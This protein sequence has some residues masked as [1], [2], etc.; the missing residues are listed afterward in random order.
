MNPQP[1]TTLLVGYGNECRGDDGLGPTVARLVDAMGLPEVSVL[2]V[3]QLTPELAEPL[4]AAGRAVFVDARAAPR[5]SPITVE[6]LEAACA[7]TVLT[8]SCRPADLL[9]LCQLLYGHSPPAWLVTI[10]GSRFDPG[11]SLSRH[12]RR[13]ADQAAEMLS[14]WLIAPTGPLHSF[15]PNT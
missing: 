3:H 5:H 14:R 2:A 8:H 15:Q 4:A 12:A 7:A 13:R 6:R 1:R 9:A 11:D 10:A